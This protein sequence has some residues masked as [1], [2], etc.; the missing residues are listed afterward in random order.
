MT[1]RAPDTLEPA[2]GW[3]ADALCARTD[4]N[5]FHPEPGTSA[6]P[7]KKVCTACPVRAECLTHALDHPE[8]D[9]V[10]GGMTI[11]ERRALKRRHG[12]QVA[13]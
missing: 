8:L 13:A 9:G 11:K 2:H 1:T 6:E 3:R 7:A 5:L 12:A 4:P 10:W